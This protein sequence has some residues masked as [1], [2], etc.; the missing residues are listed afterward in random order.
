MITAVGA[1]T[2]RQLGEVAG[3]EHETADL[4]GDVH[5]NLR[6]LARLAVFIGDGIV[7][8]VVADV[9]EVL[10]HSLFDGD[11]TGGDAQFLH[12]FQCVGV[13]GVRGAET[14]HGDRRDNG[15]GQTRALGGAHGDK[16]GKGRIQ[17]A[18]DTDGQFAARD[19]ETAG[20]GR[21]LHLENVQAARAALLFV[22]R[23]ERQTADAQQTA[24]RD[25][26]RQGQ[27]D[28]FGVFCLAVPGGA[29]RIDLVLQAIV[30][31][32]A[33]VEI[34]RQQI[35]AGG[36][37]LV[38]R[39]LRA[40]KPDHAAPRIDGVGDGFIGAGSRRETGGQRGGRLL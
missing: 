14:G 32:A 15:G 1:P 21:G 3:A 18:R 13:R 6:A 28:R 29:G 2:E 25:G 38:F 11:F 20:E 17:S 24:V 36:R 5:E 8:R 10:Q 30:T 4:I 23:Y 22:V 9:A 33:E 35:V 27:I 7:G 40:A 12:Q 31:Q 34:G 37:R 16:Q 39:D 19:G 26:E